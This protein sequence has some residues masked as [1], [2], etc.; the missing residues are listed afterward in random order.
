LP[1]EQVIPAEEQEQAA[2]SS[3]E[4]TTTTESATGDSNE[5]TEGEAK[6]KGGFQRRI[7]KLTREKADAARET[8]YWRQQALRTSPAETKVEA[9]VKAEAKPKVDDFATHAEYV[10]AIS[11][12]SAKKA[13]A[14]FK[15]EQNAEKAK[16]H[17]QTAAQTYQ[18]KLKEFR[19]ATPDFDEVLADADMDVGRAVLDEIF[20]HEQGPALA[21][22][23]AKNLDEAER[24]KK[25]PPVALAR[26]VGRLESRFVT[27][28]SKTTATVTK[29]PAPPNPVGKSTSTSTKDPG[30]MNLR[31][32]E[33]WRRTQK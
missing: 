21:Y 20:S 6:A 5:P 23:L 2:A 13:V 1:E 33:A 24:L 17:Q 16:T 8:E 12:Y 29:A 19:A 32:Y 27:A 25:L 7:D 9:P 18:G 15:A 30:E 11:E 22:Y 31:D 26:E 3:T 14:D 4:D 10:E 28:P